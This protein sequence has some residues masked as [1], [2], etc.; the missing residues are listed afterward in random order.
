MKTDAAIQFLAGTGVDTECRSVVQYLD[1]GADDWERQH[2][3]IQWAF[4]NHV[5]SAYHPNSPVVEIGKVVAHRQLPQAQSNMAKLFFN[6]L[7]SL[8]IDLND[9]Q[10]FIL[11]KG[12]P[13]WLEPGNHNYLRITRVIIALRI[14]KLDIIAEKFATFVLQ[15]PKSHPYAINNTTVTYWHKALHDKLN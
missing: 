9:Q 11:T 13:Y 8:S 4:P 15:L 2:D 1:F 10:E 5:E 12:E 7:S 3:I 14:F 6:Y